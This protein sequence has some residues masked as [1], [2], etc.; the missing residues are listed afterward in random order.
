MLPPGPS[1]PVGIQTL[2]W[3]RRPVEFL[4]A[5]RARYGD[6]FTMH[7]AP[8]GR[9]VV[10]SDP[11]DV[12]TVFTADPAIAH[13][14]RGNRILL[15]LLGPHSVLLLDGEQHLRQRK[16]LL[17]PLHGQRMQ[18]YG[19]LMADLARREIESWPQGTPFAVQEGMQALTLNI[20]VRAVFG[21][22]E[23]ERAARL[24]VELRQLMR[25]ATGPVAMA[26]VVAA[27]PER[28]ARLR[29]HRPLRR[30]YEPV[31]R[32]IGEEIARR[33]LADDLDDR[34]DILSLLLG[35]RHEDG[36]PM[37]D[38]ELRDELMTLLVAGHETTATSLAWALERLAH[39]PAQLARLTEEVRAGSE[40]YLEA[41]VTETLRLRPVLSVVVRRL[42]APLEIRGYT[43][44]AGTTVVPCIHLVHRDP[45][46]Y[47]DPTA[48]RP[49][50]FEHEGPG[51]YT[52]IPFGGGVRRCL[53][54]AFAQFEMRTVLRELLLRRD[55]ALS[56]E[57]PER[58]R[59]RAITNIPARGGTI[60]LHSRSSGAQGPGRAGGSG[61]LQGVM[62]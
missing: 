21:V 49:E 34:S 23:P 57:P 30:V 48:F 1:L 24:R 50:R 58:V 39:S 60:T 3:M 52:W 14:G 54:A 56:T 62:V 12:K 29:H 36:S 20:I 33:R 17:A 40:D 5:Q 42:T 15:P 31:D 27:G 6:T 44:P 2:R 53:G 32:L 7:I 38:A 13:A 51:T 19:E 45:Q 55:L 61:D 37:S 41:V 47:P 25:N 8:E 35:A 9:W 10:V 18:A 22:Q 59:R 16:L 46:L 28:A 26:L 4:E 43:L 11:D